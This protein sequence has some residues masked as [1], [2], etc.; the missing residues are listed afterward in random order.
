M[1]IASSTDYSRVR[2]ALCLHIV[3]D[4]LSGAARE[5]GAKN[6]GMSLGAAHSIR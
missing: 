3:W 2:V 1:V 6:V 4:V 5:G